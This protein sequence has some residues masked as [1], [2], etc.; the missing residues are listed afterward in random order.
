MDGFSGII[1]WIVLGI[2]ISVVNK[3]KK[4]AKKQQQQSDG[5]PTQKTTLQSQLNRALDQIN[6]IKNMSSD[7]AKSRQNV[8]SFKSQPTQKY[9]SNGSLE[10]QIVEGVQV[11]GYQMEGAKVEGYKV[12]GAKVEGLAQKHST[13]KFRKNTV[14]ATESSMKS[15]FAGEG[16]DEHYDMELAY[17]DS[18]S[19]KASKRKTLDFSDNQILQGIIMSQVLERPRRR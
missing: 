17:S 2:V 3:A 12:E 11:E 7:Q 6:E 5:T 9:G 8:S 10:G 16:C 18:S 1:I 15:G 14:A 19:R 4:E 13:N